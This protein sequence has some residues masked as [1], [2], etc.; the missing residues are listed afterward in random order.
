[1][2]PIIDTAAVSRL[3]ADIGSPRAAAS[4]VSRFTDLLDERILVIERSF[5]SADPTQWH[6]AV[7][8]LRSAA[9]TAGAGRVQATAALL[10][11][12]DLDA[13][14]ALAL[15]GQLRSDARI[16]TLAHSSLCEEQAFA[17]RLAMRRFA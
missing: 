17:E 12:A 5:R 4:F 14:T 3:A 9:A 8:G 11:A 1:M 15:I 2:Q 10:L 7:A 6:D 13:R 16:F